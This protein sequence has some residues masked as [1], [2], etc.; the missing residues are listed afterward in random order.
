[1][2][3]PPPRVAFAQIDPVSPADAT[4]VFDSL[5]QS[6]DS[7]C[8][9]Y[10]RIKLLDAEIKKAQLHVTQTSFWYRLIPNISFSAN[11]GVKDIIFMD[12]NTFVQYYLPKDAYRF[13]INISINEIF[14]FSK[15]TEAILNLEKCKTQFSQA[16]L[17]Y[18]QNLR[19]IQSRISATKELLTFATEELEMKEDILRYNTL[20]FE[21]GK[22]DY[23]VYISSK[24]DVLIVRINLLRLNQEIFLL[25]NKSIIES[26]P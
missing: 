21:Q 3:S 12:P 17:E 18:T 16:K 9:D 13:S 23:D 4:P 10:S 20:R 25:K 6:M 7:V 24:L 11:F 22:I 19:K 14:N 15:Y 8:L 2:C 26:L 1:L 5:I